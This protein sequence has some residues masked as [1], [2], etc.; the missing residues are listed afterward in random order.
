ML[1]F[2]KLPTGYSHPRLRRAKFARSHSTENSEEPA[3]GSGSNPERWD[4]SYRGR[5]QSKGAGRRWA[6]RRMLKIA[7]RRRCSLAAWRSA[8]EGS[9]SASE[10]RRGSYTLG[11]HPPLAI[12]R[13]WNFSTARCLLFSVAP[14]SL[15]V[16]PLATSRSSRGHEAPTSRGSAGTMRSGSGWN[17][18]LARCG[19]RPARR[20]GGAWCP[21]FGLR[22]RLAEARR[23]VAAENGPVARSTR[24][25]LHGSRS[26]PPHVGC[27]EAYSGA[28]L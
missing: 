9:W 25:Q 26:E 17:G 22:D 8:T 28:A 4:C 5:T 10:Q 1:G 11:Y 3:C 7:S 2:I 18:P 12:V 23:Q 20:S 6:T 16:E 13:G 21:P 27:Y 14:M 24:N 19:G 15:P